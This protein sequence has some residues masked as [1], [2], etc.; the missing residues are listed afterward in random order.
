MDQLI[1]TTKVAERRPLHFDGL[2]DILADVDRLANSREVRALGNWSAGQVLQHL[3][4][5]MTKSIDGFTARPPAPVRWIARL[6][7][8]RRFLTRPMS[9]GFRLPANALAEIGP[10][11]TGWDEG[12][13]N[14]R[15]A[16][17]RLKT[18]TPRQ[19]HPVFGPMSPDEWVQIHC[20]HS[21]LHLSFLIPSGG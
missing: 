14:I 9:A 19:P 8:K 11:P 3:A 16:L 21:E 4:V 12:L 13:R 2:D 1:D 15:H 18:E 20:R 6:L 10:P 5:V 17:K 7:F